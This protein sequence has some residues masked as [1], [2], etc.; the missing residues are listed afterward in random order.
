MSRRMESNGATSSNSPMSTSSASGS[1]S[2]RLG[3]TQNGDFMGCHG[4]LMGCNG[5]M[6][7]YN[8]LNINIYS[9]V[10]SHKYGKLPFAL[11]KTHYQ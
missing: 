7:R 11:G 8:G 3:A 5:D 1:K 2:E 6:L 4:D 9:L 10:N